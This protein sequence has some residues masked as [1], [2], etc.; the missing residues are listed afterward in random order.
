M[1]NYST[2]GSQ[3]IF[4]S[5]GKS[6]LAVRANVWL[7]AG[8]TMLYFI[9]SSLFGFI[10]MVGEISSLFGFF[11]TASVY[12]AFNIYDQK[13]AEIEFGD[14]FKWFPRFGR[15]FLGNL[16]LILLSLLLIIPFGFLLVSIIGFEVLTNLAKNAEV[17]K[18]DPEVFV[19]MIGGSSILIIVG[20]LMLFIIAFSLAFFA[21]PFV[22]QFTDLSLGQ[23][24]NY[25]LKI[26]RNNIGQMIIFAFLAIGLFL[27]GLLFC[28]IG[29]LVTFPMIFGTQYYFLK[30]MIIAREEPYISTQEAPQQY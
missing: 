24:I 25:S 22:M 11:L 14:F 27:L 17:L 13:K 16:V 4:D 26:G 12:A 1:S 20:L 7:F 2:I 10:P 8:F 6:W 28:G 18:G 29:L 5:L 3:S 19:S 30:D 15:L 9:V 23:A 21:F